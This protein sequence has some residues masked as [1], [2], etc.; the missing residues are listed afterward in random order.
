MAPCPVCKHSPACELDE[1]GELARYPAPTYSTRALGKKAAANRA[2]WMVWLDPD[3]FP[4]LTPAE[5][6]VL[7]GHEDGHLDGAECEEAADYQSGRLQKKWA[8][9]GEAAAD[10]LK[11]VLEHRDGQAA[12]DNLLAGFHAAD[13]PAARPRRNGALLVPCTR[14]GVELAADA[15]TA[16]EYPPRG[17][18]GWWAAVR[19]GFKPPFRASYN[20]AGL[21]AHGLPA[22]T[23]PPVIRDVT[24]RLI[25]G[26]AYVKAADDSMPPD[27]LALELQ[28]VLLPTAQAFATYH[29]PADPLWAIITDQARAY[30]PDAARLYA[31]A[32]FAIINHEAGKL[33]S[34]G[35]DPTSIN[36][37]FTDGTYAGGSLSAPPSTAG[38]TIKSTDYGLGE[39]NDA[40][41]PQ[42]LNA[43]GLRSIAGLP[44]WADARNNVGMIAQ[45]LEAYRAQYPNNLEAQLSHYG[46]PTSAKAE[47]AL[48]AQLG[49]DPAD[50][51]TWSMPEAP[52]PDTNPVV[53]AVQSAAV[54]VDQAV[55]SLFGPS[56]VA[57]AGPR[58]GFW[59]AA[60]VV[61]GLALGAALY[62]VARHRRPTLQGAF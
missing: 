50:P 43:P 30:F 21:R 19:A 13:A 38:K 25:S 62:F 51:S 16:S 48:L 3:F 32:I 39:I 52:A 18:K 24:G 54:K 46:N 11:R 35:Y 49:I 33:A 1:P 47:L 5:Q 44:V 61:L 23:V 40:Y 34:G 56:S 45:V 8:L 10:T 60:V 36:Y 55:G 53:A 28:Q 17:S 27:P 22:P 31:Y 29:D 6:L 37:N 57:G 42:L 14:E 7:I 41:W 12:H 59:I 4:N 26:P 20:P 15:P 2:L 9:D 58:D